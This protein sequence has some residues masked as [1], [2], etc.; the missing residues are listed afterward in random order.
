MNFLDYMKTLFGK[1]K[2]P[3]DE[4]Q[5]AKEDVL[6]MTN[7]PTVKAPELPEG[8]KYDRI[9]YDAPTDEEIAQTA[10]KE[11]EAY[12]N[13]S[14]AAIERE[15]AAERARLEKDK[16][17]GS[18]R[19]ES[20]KRE[21]N[22]AYDEADKKVSDDVLRRGVARSSIAVNRMADLAE[23]RAGSIAAAAAELNA[24]IAE[25]DGELDALAFKREQA[26]NSF[27]ISLAA[28]LTERINELK[29]ARYERQAEVTK[30]NNSLSEK[31]QAYAADKVR[32]DADLYSEALSQREK[33]S[34]YAD[35]YGKDAATEK[36]VYERLRAA[37]SAM[38]ADDARD[39]LRNDT[40][41]EDNLSNYY[42]Y[43]LYDEFGR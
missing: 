15:T 3:A 1:K 41:F 2:A 20:E 18:A 19:L 39:A 34:E 22:A 29:D 5:A 4:L 16:A 42:Y 9:E 37:L 6:A 12:K 8:V 31:E 38:D 33:E 17:D 10:E 28:K 27:N 21:I 25:I 43:L 36:A 40:F 13:E 23:A 11:L 35:T 26:L 30:Y 24:Q 14:I 32:A 7:A